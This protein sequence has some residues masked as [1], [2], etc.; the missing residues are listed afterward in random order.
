MKGLTLNSHLNFQLLDVG[1]I[2]IT[3]MA[4]LLAEPKLQVQQSET[5]P[6]L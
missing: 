4:I 2:N 6:H 5:L 3:V 1:P